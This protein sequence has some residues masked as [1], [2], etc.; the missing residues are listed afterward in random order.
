MFSPYVC[1]APQEQHGDPHTHFL[2]MD[3][4]ILCC[5]VDVVE[6]HPLTVF[7]FIEMMMMIITIA[8]A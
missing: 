3:D 4:V 8:I 6:N 1:P 5:N 7:Q 2:P